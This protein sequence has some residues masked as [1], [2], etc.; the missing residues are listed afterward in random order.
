MRRGSTPAVAV[1]TT[2]A[3]GRRCRRDTASSVAR[4]QAAAPSLSG[5]EFP[6]VTV[7]SATKTGGSLASASM[8]ASGRGPSSM[9]TTSS[10]FPRRTA[11]G[12]SSSENIPEACAATARRWLRSANSSC[13]VRS[14][15]YSR[16]STSAVSPMDS[17]CSLG[18]FGLTSRHPMAV[19]NTSCSRGNALSGLG[20]TN[21]ARVMDSTPPA[22][23][24]AP[25][26]ARSSAD[27]LLIA[28]SPEPQ[29]R[30]TVT[31]PVASGSPAS[32]TAM[33][34]T[35]RLSSPAWLLAPSHTSS[36]SSGR[37]SGLRRNSAPS[38]VA[39]R[40]SGRAPESAPR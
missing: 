20:M 40:S 21:G 37:I 15:S 24:I 25:L 23:A 19:S 29:R 27:A 5:L 14:I 26:P 28:C 1:A 35:L 33:R 31:P 12:T 13:T 34:A 6:A 9:V 36:T 10:V 39:A 4:M 17:V 32:S 2:R 18:I 30:L 22:I 16:A 7:P 3:T 8:V 38:T 11:T